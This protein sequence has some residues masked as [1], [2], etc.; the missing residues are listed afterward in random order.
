[1]SQLRALPEHSRELYDYFKEG[2]KSY[3]AEKQSRT[4]LEG[5]EGA[6]DL[7]C[8]EESHELLNKIEGILK[9]PLPSITIGDEKFVEAAKNDKVLQQVKEWVKSGKG[10]ED[11][12]KLEPSLRRYHN[13]L[14][15]LSINEQGLLCMTY[16]NNRAKGT[17]KLVCVP[18]EMI[19]KVMA[20]HHEVASGHLAA[21]KIA[22]KILQKFYFPD[23]QEQVRLFCRTCRTNVYYKKG[24][25]PKLKPIVY[26]YPGLC[27]VMDV[28]MVKKTGVD[29]KVLTVTDK[30]T[31]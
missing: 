26:N 23:M 3:Y 6:H 24:E 16:Y 29:S 9:N 4:A 22:S 31:K 27:V 7:A 12:M 19:E 21:E 30:F 1:M 18:T 10:V 11:P 17:R 5:E 8:E 20:V 15:R 2:V 14:E 13:K 28:V 25:V